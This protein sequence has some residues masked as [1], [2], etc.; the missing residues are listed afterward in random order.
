MS[1]FIEEY[2]EYREQQSITLSEISERTKINVK[3]LEA[4]E[5]GNFELLPETYI[6]LFLRAYANEIGVDPDEAIEQYNLLHGKPKQEKP[7]SEQLIDEKAQEPEEITSS[8]RLDIRPRRRFNWKQSLIVILVFAFV[9]WAVKSYV[10]S[11]D[12]TNT[13]PQQT[14]PSNE[15]LLPQDTLNGQED[16]TSPPTG[17]NARQQSQSS[18]ENQA[19]KSSATQITTAAADTFEMQFSATQRTWVRIQMDTLPRQEFTFFGNDSKVWHAQHEIRLMIGNAA[20]AHIRVDGQ[21]YNN[22]G[23]QNQVVSLVIN[24]NGIAERR[25]I[26]QPQSTRTTSALTDTTGM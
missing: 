26:E 15:Q 23:E 4:I 5:E 25:V 8:Q 16:T 12:E 13:P 18:P 22:L 9:L 21:S 7:K 1:K 3:F 19:Q 2:R 20:G 24:Q 10:S 11:S 14:T 17:Q 6:R